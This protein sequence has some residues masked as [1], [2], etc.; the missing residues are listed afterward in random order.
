MTFISL[1]MGNIDQLEIFTSPSPNVTF[2]NVTLPQLT[3]VQ[4]INVGYIQTFDASNLTTIGGGANFT[5]TTIQNLTLNNLT[6]VGSSFN[7]INAYSMNTLRFDKLET[8]GILPEIGNF[9]I[10]NSSYLSNVSLPALSQVNG[11]ILL[12]GNFSR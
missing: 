8:V 5:E 7:I 6:S 3:T 2:P 9:V 1:P 10:E 11:G 12:K 4:N